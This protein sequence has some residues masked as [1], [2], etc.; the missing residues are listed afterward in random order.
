MNYKYTPPKYSV[1][2]KLKQLRLRLF[3]WILKQ[4]NFNLDELGNTFSFPTHL[5]KT[6]IKS[7]PKKDTE[8]WSAFS[9]FFDRIEEFDVVTGD[10]VLQLHEIM[11][12][13]RE[14]K[15][16]DKSDQIRT[17]IG[18]LARVRST[19]FRFNKNPLYKVVRGYK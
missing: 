1:M 19:S 9:V 4:S 3:I 2:T 15:Q 12:S 7:P 13:L 14:E 16:F 10:V 11:N 17:L 8:L 5:L 6:L 18:E